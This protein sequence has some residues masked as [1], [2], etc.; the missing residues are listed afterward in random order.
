MATTN[1]DIQDYSVST[2]LRV[3]KSDGFAHSIRPYLEKAAEDV[4][5]DHGEGS[6]EYKVMLAILNA[7]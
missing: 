2:A 6:P 3:A 4:A 7:L 5:S 1:S